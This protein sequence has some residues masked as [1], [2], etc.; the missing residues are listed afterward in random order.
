MAIE[1]FLYFQ[2]GK[3]LSLMLEKYRG[4]I[5]MMIPDYEGFKRFGFFQDPGHADTSGL[6]RTK[7]HDPPFKINR[8]NRG[9]IL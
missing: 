1:L 6:I 8:H 7:Y 2:V 3:S 5:Q 4:N 9:Y